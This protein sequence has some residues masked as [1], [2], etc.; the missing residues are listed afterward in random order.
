MPANIVVAPGTDSVA[1]LISGVENG[2]FIE[3]FWY[4][5]V[6][7]PSKT[8]LTGVSR[9]AAWRIRDGHLSTPVTGARWT[10]N[11]FGVLHRVDGISAET[12]AQPLSNIWNGCVTAPALRVRGFR[13]GPAAEIERGTAQ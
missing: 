8:T 5:R 3:R 10:E 6:V 12:R 1:D 7:D 13:F 2:L 4:L 11:V 9:D